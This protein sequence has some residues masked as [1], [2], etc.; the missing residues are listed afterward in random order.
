MTELTK[1]RTDH[2]LHQ[3]IHRPGRAQPAR[4]VDVPRTGLLHGLARCESALQADVA[5]HGLGGHPACD[6]HAGVHLPVRWWRPKC[7]PTAFHIRLFIYC[8]AAL[9]TVRHCAQPGQPLANLAHNNM[10]TKIYF[11]RLI[12]PMSSV[13]ADGGFCDRICHPDWPDVLLSG[14][15][16]LERD[17]GRFRSSSCLAIVTALGVAL[18]LSA[19]NVQYRDVN[20]ALPFLTQFWLF[21]HLLRIPPL[22]FRKSG[23]L[24]YSLN[25]MAGVVERIPLGAARRWQRPGHHPVGLCG[26]F[27]ADLYFGSVLFPQ[28]GKDLCG[29]YL[30]AK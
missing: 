30:S 3:T 1:T 4:P 8:A 21:P 22:S 18:W 26:H 28:H 14:H 5:G 16:G 2:H 20:Y 15:A 12:L 17:S 23:R 25:P 29:Y 19:I 10:V 13:F 24:V 27:C 7:R 11:P 6:D 9:G